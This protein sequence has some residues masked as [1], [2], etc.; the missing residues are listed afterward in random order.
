MNFFLIVGR[1]CF[2]LFFIIEGV[3]KILNWNDSEQ[4]LITGLLN[5]LQYVQGAEWPQRLLDF[6]LPHSSEVLLASTVAELAGGALVFLGVGVRVGA[7]LLACFLVPTTLIFYHFWWIDG[8]DKEQ[9][10]MQF[11]R[12]LAL[13]GGC[14]VFFSQ[15]IKPTAKK[16][17]KSG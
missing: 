4:A 1:M 14:L 7:F 5:T 15:G 13:F 17:P 6:L 11:L 16:K 12:N 9:N 8:L 3:T 2:A 10:V